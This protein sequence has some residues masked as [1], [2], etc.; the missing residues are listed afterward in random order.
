[1][2][3]RKWLMLFF[4]ANIVFIV[5]AWKSSTEDSNLPREARRGVHYH[6]KRHMLPKE[7]D[8]KRRISTSKPGRELRK[9]PAGHLKPL[10]D[11]DMENDEVVSVAIGP[12]PMRPKF[13]KPHKRPP[14][15]KPKPKINNT[16]A[17]NFAKDIL[18]QLGTEFI[19]HQVNEDFVFGQFIGNSIRNLTSELKIKM[20][21]DILEL[22]MK[23]QRLN[24]GDVPVKPEEKYTTHG[25]KD[26]KVEKKSNDTEE[27]WP[28]FTNLAKIVG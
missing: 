11:D 21:H 1:M 23:Y 26:I 16:T 3:R 8:R 13:E 2:D 14:P 5:G 7:V 4:I 20:Q 22:I 28:D 27:S 10:E 19:F 24:R 18:Q 25:L 6:S 12:P 15:V 9:K 17:I